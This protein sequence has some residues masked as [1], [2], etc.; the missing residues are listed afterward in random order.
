V[1]TWIGTSTPASRRWIASATRA[2]PRRVAPASTIATALSGLPWPYAYPFTTP[3]TSAPA[4]IPRST[5]TLWRMAA[6]S[7]SAHTGCP[8]CSI[9]SLV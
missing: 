1:K 8:R 2:T 9:S 4:A 6:R 7:T 3:M 5:P